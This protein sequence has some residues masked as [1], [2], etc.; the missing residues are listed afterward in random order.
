MKKRI[1]IIPLIICFLLLPILLTIAEAASPES[2]IK[3]FADA[4]WYCLVTLTTVG[5]GDFYPVTVFGKIIGAVLVLLSLGLLAT[6]TGVIVSL[7]TGNLLPR[8]RLFFSRRKEWFVFGDGSEASLTLAARLY[9]D[10]DCMLVFPEDVDRAALPHGA[11]S[12]SLSEE[13]LLKMHGP[14]GLSFFYL[15]ADDAA[16]YRRAM[17]APAGVPVY[18]LSSFDP[19]GIPCHISMVDRNQIVSRMYWQSAPLQPSEQQVVFIGGGDV[20]DALLEQAMIANVRL[21]GNGVTYHLFGGFD[22][23]CR[24]HPYLDA[25]MAVNRDGQ[26]DDSFLFHTESWESCPELL[27]RAD[28]IILCAGEADN[29]RLLQRLRHCYAVSGKVYVYA[30]SAIPGA[31]SFG[32]AGQVYTPGLIIGGQINRMARQMHELYRNGAGYDVPAWEGL[33][34]FLKRSNAAAA[35]HLPMKVS[36]LCGDGCPAF[37]EDFNFTQAAKCYAGLTDEQRRPYREAEH[38]RWMRFH[39]VNGWHYAATRDNQARLHPLMVPF[40]SLSPEEQRKDDYAWELIGK[41]AGQ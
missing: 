21:L 36:I 29:L 13:A 17:A 2:S 28:R 1:W 22:G 18:C 40:D 7:F 33:S 9:A 32:Q 38:R 23:F 39:A 5:Y 19:D 14:G 4:L 24:S 16:N 20:A 27:Y 8:L 10:G 35:D 6:L 15:S 37:P 12:A 30:A 34:A 25:A 41:L 26:G 3:S 11:V 31:I